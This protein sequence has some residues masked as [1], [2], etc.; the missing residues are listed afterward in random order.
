MLCTR[1]LTNSGE[2]KANLSAIMKNLKVSLSS[3]LSY[4]IPVQEQ[5]S[6][7]AKRAQHGDNLFYAKIIQNVAK[8]QT[9][10]KS[11]PYYIAS[12]YKLLWKMVLREFKNH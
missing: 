10:T 8:Y 12:Y 11:E 3:V 9:F 5:R 4:H 7:K 1:L 6:A 2:L